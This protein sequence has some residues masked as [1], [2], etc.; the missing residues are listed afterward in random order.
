[1]KIINTVLLLLAT[2][3]AR[4]A[5]A[6]YLVNQGADIRINSGSSLVIAG[7]FRNSLD[8]TITNSGNLFVSGNWTNDASSGNLLQGT[9]GTVHFNGAIAQNIAGTTK[10]WFS[11]LNM[12]NHAALGVETSVSSLLTLVNKSVTLG[13]YNLVMEGSASISG[14]SSLGYVVAA[15]TGKLL[16]QVGAVNTQFPVGTATSY[17]PVVLNNS[18]TVDNFGVNVFADVRQNGTTGGTIPQINDCVNMTWVITENVAGGSNL[19]VTPYWNAS[20]EGVSFDRTNCGVGHYT[21]GAWNPQSSGA[22]GGANPYFIT[23]TGITSLS[24]FAVGDLQ[25]PMAIPLHIVLD[26]TAL[27]EGP[28]NGATMNPTLNSGGYL[29]LS[30]PYNIAPW[31][32]AGSENV[33]AIPNANVIDWVLVELRDATS[34]PNATGATMIARQAAFVLSDGTIVAMDGASDLLF[35]NTVINQLFVVV[36]HRNHLGVMSANPLVNVGGIYSYNF[37]TAA[38]QAYGADAHKLLPGGKYGMYGAD[39]NAD[40]AVNTTDKNN[41]WKPT[42]GT[43]GYKAGDFN[44]NAHVNNPDKN[45]I[46][47]PNNGKTSKVPN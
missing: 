29:P 31:N 17:V 38:G 32:Y 35:N 26:V 43:K 33:G 23:R 41:V 6:Q 24:A 46:W 5:V 20:N 4:D 14:A 2:L 9:T 37:T 28:Y 30:Q 3:V 12:L 22:A 13:S 45:G 34:A 39:G 25:S 7:N 36:W 21:G 40:K 42:A 27:L 16:R 10:T 8:G 47:V 18:G 11:N 44:L 1:M 15:G 19:S